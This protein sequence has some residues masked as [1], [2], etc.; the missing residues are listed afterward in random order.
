[1]KMNPVD[2]VAARKRL[3][4]A[5]VRMLDEAKSTVLRSGDFWSAGQFSRFNRCNREQ[6]NDWQRNGQIFA[7]ENE[8]EVYWPIYAFSQGEACPSKTMT[9]VLKIFG[10]TKSGWNLAFWFAGLNS[11]LDDERPQDLLE[12][13]PLGVIDAAKD[14]LNGCRMRPLPWRAQ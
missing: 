10:N 4:E 14:E 3:L 11:F 5:Q 13:N 6:L 7:I 1:M 8:G 9:T 2:F 12:T